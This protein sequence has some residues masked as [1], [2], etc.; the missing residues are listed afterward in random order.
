MREKTSASES[1]RKFNVHWI[2]FVKNSVYRLVADDNS[3]DGHSTPNEFSMFQVWAVFNVAP[4]SRIVFEFFIGRTNNN[5]R[6]RIKSNAQTARRIFRVGQFL[7]YYKVILRE[8]KIC[9]IV[10]TR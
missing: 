3:N 2:N 9:T 1:V 10:T 4:I 8:W 5:R 7:K 6:M